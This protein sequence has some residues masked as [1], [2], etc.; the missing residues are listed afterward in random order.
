MR[1]TPVGLAIT[2]FQLV[3]S[4]TLYVSHSVPAML[5]GGVS[6]GIVFGL[7][8]GRWIWKKNEAEFKP[9]QLT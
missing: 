8:Y 1:G 9:D 3:F 6:G 5:I 7:L 4:Y 2:I